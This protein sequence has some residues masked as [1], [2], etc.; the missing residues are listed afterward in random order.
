MSLLDTLLFWRKPSLP[1]APNPSKDDPRIYLTDDDLDWSSISRIREALKGKA[2][3]D[4]YRI[5]LKGAVLD[6]SRITR[7]NNQQNETA[8]GVRLRVN[9][10]TLVNGW[11]SDIP[12]GIKVMSTQT[13]FTSLKFIKIGEDALSTVGPDATN[14]T[15]RNL[16]FWN[17]RIGDKSLQLNQALGAVLTNIKLVGGITGIRVQKA[18]YNT[19]QVTVMIDGV[20]FIGCETGM[21]IDGKATVRLHNATFT[22]VKKK[23]VFGTKGG[24]KVVQS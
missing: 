14:I 4:G 24:G 5:D 2:T 12:G 3:I 1:S 18:S 21:N 13:R 6:G 22:N 23:W 10:V 11:I 16:E 7:P 20:T 8:L 19:P 9:G 15:L 17:D